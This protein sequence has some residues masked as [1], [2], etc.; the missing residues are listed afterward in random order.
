MANLTPSEI[1]VNTRCCVTNELWKRAHNGLLGIAETCEQ[2]TLLLYYKWRIISKYVASGEVLYYDI[3]AC[4]TINLTDL[5]AQ[6][7]DGMKLDVVINTPTGSTVIITVTGDFFGFTLNQFI[8]YLVNLINTTTTYVATNNNPD[9]TICFTGQS[10]TALTD[11][12]ISIEIAGFYFLKW[13]ESNARRIAT[14]TLGYSGTSFL[15]PSYVP[16]VAKLIVPNGDSI[17][18]LWPA[19]IGI[20][21]VPPNNNPPP[22]T[23]TASTA[24][25]SFTGAV[26]GS[27]F[28]T[29]IASGLSVNFFK[30]GQQFE[31]FA[32]VIDTTGEVLYSTQYPGNS[33]ATGNPY[34]NLYR[35][36]FVINSTGGGY[37]QATGVLNYTLVNWT[38]Q[39]NVYT[40]AFP[41]TTA[42]QAGGAYAP[43]P[44]VPPQA[45]AVGTLGGTAIGL[46][47]WTFDPAQLGW[48]TVSIFLC[49]LGTGDLTWSRDL[50]VNVHCNTLGESSV[51]ESNNQVYLSGFGADLY[52]S[53][54]VQIDPATEAQ[55]GVVKIGTSVIVPAVSGNTGMRRNPATG[56]NYAF[57]GAVL[58]KIGA[59][60]QYDATAGR[61]VNCGSI[62]FDENGGIYMATT[63]LSPLVVYWIQDASPSPILADSPTLTKFTALDN[64]AGAPLNITRDYNGIPIFPGITYPALQE[65]FI[66]GGLDQY[67]L[68]WVST[69][70][71][72]LTYTDLTGAG[73]KYR[74]NCTVVSYDNG[75]GALRYTINTMSSASPPLTTPPTTIIAFPL[76]G[77]RLWTW[78]VYPSI[79]GAIAIEFHDATGRLYVTRFTTSGGLLQSYDIYAPNSTVLLTEAEILLTRTNYF[80]PNYPTTVLSGNLNY[81]KIEDKFFL[82]SSDGQEIYVFDPNTQSFDPRPIVHPAAGGDP[83]TT[84]GTQLLSYTADESFRDTTGINIYGNATEGSQN[85]VGVISNQPPNR[86][87]FKGVFSGSSTE[88]V[89]TDADNCQTLVQINKPAEEVKNW[90]GCGSCS[91]NIEDINPPPSDS[92]VTTYA[93]FYGRSTLTTLNAA[94]VQ[95]LT[96]IQKSTFAGVYSFAADAVNG[97]CYVAFPSS[98]G[99]PASIINPTTGFDIPMNTTFTVTINSIVYTAYRSYFE[100]HGATQFQFNQ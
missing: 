15:R 3:A 18:N 47:F 59:A 36:R 95:A 26:A 91:D 13:T 23:F 25:L 34:S 50:E 17:V 98:F 55:V 71:F 86:D 78:E 68:I 82:P 48:S 60:L 62:A 92:N 66:G 44:T 61:A 28:T 63:R 30:T 51:N 49:N 84:G 45:P 2:E 52:Y 6:L 31:F 74:L 41:A 69:A 29:T 88:V 96:S 24:L 35:L 37:N 33:L 5:E 72:V 81:Q 42:G 1:A 39:S 43:T 9:I 32:T 7:A 64:T 53:G 46:R 73:T 93:V 94:Q 75:T 76:T 57:S 67:G 70:L 20:G 11:T 85:E 38:W 40:S 80:P 14:K 87:Q 10:D 65:E 4:A 77:T 100:L 12:T 56:N 21:S 79:K 19:T 8:I 58:S 97:Y 83:T 16:S 89:R 99:V 22:G 27:T 90:C 54:V